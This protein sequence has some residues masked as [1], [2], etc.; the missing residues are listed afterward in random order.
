[1]IVFCQEAPDDDLLDKVAIPLGH[2]L[3]ADIAAG[4]HCDADSGIR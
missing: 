4:C 2:H 3:S 1:M